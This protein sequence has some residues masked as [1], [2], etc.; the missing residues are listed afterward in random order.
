MKQDIVHGLSTHF[1]CPTMEDKNKTM[2][3]MADNTVT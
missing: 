2:S 3:L 1:I